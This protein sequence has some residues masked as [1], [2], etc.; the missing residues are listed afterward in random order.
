MKN[1]GIYI[2]YRDGETMNYYI[3]RNTKMPSVLAEI[4]FISSKEDNKKYDDNIEEYAKAIA[5]GIEMT[6]KEMNGE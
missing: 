6:L 4:G 2:G 3:N 5:D 1:R